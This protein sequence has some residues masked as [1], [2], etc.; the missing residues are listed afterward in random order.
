MSNVQYLV[1]QLHAYIYSGKGLDIRAA[2]FG[3]SV[4]VLDQ[5][6]HSFGGMIKYVYVIQVPILLLM[7]H[8]QMTN[9]D[10]V[11]GAFM[12]QYL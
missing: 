1:E 6:H 7:Y 12:Y 8:V 5:Y 4:S 9:Y 11:L 3:V 2:P 10:C